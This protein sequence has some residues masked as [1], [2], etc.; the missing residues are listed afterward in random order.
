M[1]N[2]DKVRVIQNGRTGVVVGDPVQ[3][4]GGQ[5]RVQVRKPDAPSLRNRG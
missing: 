5:V 3:G 1:K 2:G 4:T